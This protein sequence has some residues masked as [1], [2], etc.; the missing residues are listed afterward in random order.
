M[1]NVWSAVKIGQKRKRERE[2]QQFIVKT[3]FFLKPWFRMW[4]KNDRG[5]LVPLIQW[6]YVAIASETIHPFFFLVEFE[7]LLLESLTTFNY[8]FI[9]S[10]IGKQINLSIEGVLL[11]KPGWMMIF[12]LLFEQPSILFTYSPLCYACKE[13][14]PER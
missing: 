3:L 5:K 14:F 2:K 7:V 10:A 4:K 1:A 6:Q 8:F 9:I 12:F 11:L 13:T